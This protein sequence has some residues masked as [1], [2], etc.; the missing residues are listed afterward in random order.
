MSSVQRIVRCLLLRHAV[1]EI[2]TCK[3]PFA[4]ISMD[5]LMTNV[6]DGAKYRPQ[7]EANKWSSG[8]LDLLTKA[9]SP[10]MSLRP[11]M[12]EIETTLRLQVVEGCGKEAE[13]GKRLS[14]QTRR[15]T[16]VQNKQ[17]SSA[18]RIV[19]SWFDS[20]SKSLD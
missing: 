1:W 17:G 11:T 2:L 4:K 20:S 8:I 19:A 9:W 7:L 5:Q 15:S 10:N 12:K 16:Y 13:E 6:W 3:K 14:H 18:S